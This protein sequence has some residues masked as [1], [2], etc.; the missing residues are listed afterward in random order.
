LKITVVVDNNVP[1][2]AKVAFRGE[3]GLAVLIETGANQILFDTGQSDIVLHNL[4]LL[5]VHPRDLDA[6][7]LSHGHYDH[8]GG[9]ASVLAMAGK[10]IPVF[11]HPGIF[12]PRYAVSG[13]NCR[14]VGV[15]YNKDYLAR[16]GAD[17]RSVE[18]PLE[19]VPNL[20]ISGPIPRET[21][22]EE[23]DAR[24]VVT[25]DGSECDCGD[26][27]KD[28]KRDPLID[29]MAIFIRCSKGLLLL[30]GCAHSGI[31]N[32]V[33]HGLKV[34]GSIKVHGLLG[35]THL[36]PTSDSQQS[37]TFAALEWF[38]PDFIASNHCTGFAVM[39]KMAQTFGAKFIPAFCGTVI[40]C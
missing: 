13:A 10:K 3:H 27:Q 7:V 36:G 37:A 31:I 29:D 26:S 35:G 16:L 18:E 33:N 2:L 25:S 11:S 21:S 5:G 19:L 4:G 12:Q 6:I 17:F 34:T 39:A 9:L 22:Y 28:F 38:N 30:G 32:M 1:T 15:P 23:G 14:Y 40:E 8:T 20:W 24:L